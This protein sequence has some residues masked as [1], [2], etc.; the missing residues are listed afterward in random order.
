MLP[1]SWSVQRGGTRNPGRK[2]SREACYLCVSRDVA[3]DG[4]GKHPQQSKKKN[5]E[6]KNINQKK[7]KQNNK[8]KNKKNSKRNIKVRLKCLNRSHTL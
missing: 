7:K 5:N 1:H 4:H 3:W 8:K 6:Q 2:D